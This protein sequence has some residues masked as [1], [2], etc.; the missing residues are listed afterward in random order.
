MYYS[1][2]E[3]LT[4]SLVT[5]LNLVNPEIK[6]LNT[7]VPRSLV[8]I[9]MCY[10]ILIFISYFKLNLSSMHI[11]HKNTNRNMYVIRIVLFFLLRYVILSNSNDECH[12][13]KC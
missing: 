3:C 13:L 10:N 5:S 9:C 11:F 2:K 12:N 4:K 8:S 7:F 6:Y 1:S